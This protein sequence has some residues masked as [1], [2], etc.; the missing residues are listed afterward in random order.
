MARFFLAGAFLFWSVFV[1]SAQ[2]AKFSGAYL[3]HVCASDEQGRELVPGG[4]TACQAYIAGLVDYH[5][6][7]RSLGTAPSV[8]FCIPE[9]VDVPEL[10]KKIVTY[11][12]KNPENHEQF[13]AAPGVALGLFESYPCG[14]KK[15]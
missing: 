7:I 2:A 4:H 3:M 1:P 5:T 14:K 11:L 13:L 8:D 12:K 15:K 9:S 6:L 10:Q